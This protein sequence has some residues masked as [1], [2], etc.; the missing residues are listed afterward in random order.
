MQYPSL[1]ELPPP[2]EG[3]TGWPWTEE[4]APLPETM[5]DG[6]PWPRITVVTPSFNQGPFI[7][8][9]IR[10]VLLQ[11]YPDVEYLVFDGGSTDNT[12][13]I[14]KK[15][16]KWI[17]HWESTPDRGQS[18][19][20]NKGFKRA[21][22]DIVGWINS[23]DVYCKDAFCIAAQWLSKEDGV[24]FIYGDCHVVGEKGDK[25]D[26]YKGKFYP[27]QDFRAYWN[28]YVPQPSVFFLRDVIHEVGLLDEGLDLV[29]DYD[30]WLR[31]SLKYFLYYTNEVMACFRIHGVS[32][33]SVH[34]ESFD[35]ELDRAVRR[36]W[37]NPFSV[38]YLKYWLSR[39]RFRSGIL[40]WRAYRAMQQGK[41]KECL[42]HMAKSIA[43]YPPFFLGRRF[44]D[45]ENLRARILPLLSGITFSGSKRPR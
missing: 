39:N 13:D 30:F 33:T 43:Y 21:S 14:I 32:K 40:R 28:H 36:Y 5:P 16:G 37:G 22:G 20:I 2:P 7:E 31:C 42:K 26:Y 24:Y 1:K 10:S 6:T 44:Y 17:E 4:S 38:A 35:L 11:G 8:E 9:T 3:K 45:M 34:K 29:M 41:H 25:I 15:Y 12:L 18:H 27:S 19:A 23:D